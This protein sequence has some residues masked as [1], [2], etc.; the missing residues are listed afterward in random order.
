M[1]QTAAR[2]EFNLHEAYQGS[3]GRWFTIERRPYKGY[4]VVAWR[5]DNGLYER[6]DRDPYQLFA[7][8]EYA[9]S[10]LRGKGCRGNG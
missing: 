8:Y 4:S 6:D 10:N 2:R 9:E 3:D 1:K 7:K 5:F